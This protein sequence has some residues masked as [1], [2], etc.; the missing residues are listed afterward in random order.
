MSTQPSPTLGLGRDAGSLPISVDP[1]ARASAE[2][3]TPATLAE[4]RQRSGKTMILL[5][6]VIT[7]VG[8]VLYCAVCFASGMDVDLGD[9]LLRN[10]V[11]L[12]RLTLGV[13]GLGTLVWLVGSFTYLRGAMDADEESGSAN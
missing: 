8:V 11:P 4:D 7:V 1:R 10:T 5:G 6:F 12:A 13:L 9:V 2:R 3:A